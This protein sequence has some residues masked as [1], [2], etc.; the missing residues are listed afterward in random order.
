VAVHEKRECSYL[1]TLKYRGSDK[2]LDR[3]TSLCIL[4]DGENISFDASLV[5]YINST[6]IPPIIIIIMIYEHKIFCRCSLFPSWS[7]YGLSRTPVHGKSVPIFVPAH[8]NTAFCAQN[9]SGSDILKFCIL[10]W[11][12]LYM[13]MNLYIYLCV[14]C[15]DFPLFPVL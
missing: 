9:D 6:N 7:G 12:I 2:S 10:L 8:D 5:V 1:L 14:S 13:C 11:K 15:M 4:F 3:P